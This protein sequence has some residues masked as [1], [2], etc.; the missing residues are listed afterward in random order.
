MRACS[1]A[2]ALGVVLVSVKGTLLG[3]EALFCPA[4]FLALLQS[5][6]LFCCASDDAVSGRES[7]TVAWGH[8]RFY[9]SASQLLRGQF[10]LEQPSWGLRAGSCR[11]GCFCFWS[12][13][14]FHHTP[15]PGTALVPRTGMVALYKYMQALCCSVAAVVL[16]EQCGKTEMGLH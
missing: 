14:C 10:K 16:L 2:A 8:L 4:S 13:E 11:P 7:T 9:S 3:E 6:V 1:R 5:A 12:T 15:S